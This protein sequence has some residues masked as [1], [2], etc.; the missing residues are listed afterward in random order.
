MEITSF[1]QVGKESFGKLCKGSIVDAYNRLTQASIPTKDEQLLKN[2]MSSKGFGCSANRFISKTS[3]SPGPGYYSDPDILNP[4]LSKKGYGGL[5][6]S[7]ARFKKY[8][9]VNSIPGPGSYEDQPISSQCFTISN[10][11]TMS[12]K[13]TQ[14]LPAPGQYDP[15]LPSSSTQSTSMFKSKSKRLE[16]PEKISPAPWQYTPNY[17]LTRNS[18]SALSSAF[19]LSVNAKREPKNL[20]DPHGNIDENITPGPGDYNLEIKYDL[21]RPS[22]MF[23]NNEQDRFGKNKNP[24]IKNDTPGPGQYVKPEFTTKSKIKGAAF[25]SESERKCFTIK[26]KP[27]GPAFYK[28]TYQPK[29]KSFHLKPENIWV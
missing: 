9:Y 21:N 27:P 19:K 28:P 24:K 18:S 11:K 7:A 3:R 29:K 26:R 22:S 16:I 10:G 13:K 4:S 5:T 2:S 20:Y 25:M 6:N 12:L 23:V 17:N 15:L 14:D 1:R 8:Q